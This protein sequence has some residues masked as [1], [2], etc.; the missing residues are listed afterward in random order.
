AAGEPLGRAPHDHR[1][2][3]AGEELHDHVVAALVLAELEGLHDVRV[4]EHGGKPRL[5]EEHLDELGVVGEVIVQ[6]LD[7]D[8]LLEPG[9]TADPREVNLGRSAQ[10][11]KS[12]DLVLAET[13]AKQRPGPRRNTG[14]WSV[15]YPEPGFGLRATGYGK[16]AQSSMISF[17]L[18]FAM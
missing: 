12:Q 9:R 6:A 14:H 13:L 18:A 15:S 7:D 11:E 10:G 16:G 17:S 5:V 2:R 4:I 8:V 1:Q 3:Q